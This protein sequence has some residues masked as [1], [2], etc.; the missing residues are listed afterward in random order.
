MK[1]FPLRLYQFG[2]VSLKNDKF[3]SFFCI[4]STIS[5]YWV[6]SNISS[7]AAMLNVQHIPR[8]LGKV[9]KIAEQLTSRPFQRHFL[10]KAFSLAK[11]DVTFSTSK[12]GNCWVMTKR[13]F[14]FCECD[15]D[16]FFHE[17]MNIKWSFDVIIVFVM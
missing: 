4:F 10:I 2:T 17:R 8:S 6:F 12:Q 15:L 16:F 7:A 1:H 13:N 5:V 11:V 9:L 3:P 14:F